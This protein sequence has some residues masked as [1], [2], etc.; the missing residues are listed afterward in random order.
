MIIGNEINQEP[1]NQSK[2]EKVDSSIDEKKLNLK[3]IPPPYKNKHEYVGGTNEKACDSH[4]RESG[5][6]P[7]DTYGCARNIDDEYKNE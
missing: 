3:L 6:Y 2:K 1:E 7:I 4:T 5:D